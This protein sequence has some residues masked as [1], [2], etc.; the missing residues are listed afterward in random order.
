MRLFALIAL[1]FLAACSGERES[2]LPADTLVRLSSADVRSL[3]PNV[4]TDIV[5]AN[6]AMDQFEGLTRY[7][8]RGEVVGALAESWQVA[9][10]GF[11]WTF[12]LKSGLQFSD[13]T[14][15]DAGLFP[16]LFARIVDEDNPSPHYLLYT[17]VDRIE[18]PDARTVVVRLKQPFPELPALFAHQSMAAVPLHRI[19]ELGE[20]WTAE[21]PMVV[22]GPYRVTEWVLNRRILTEA[23][24][25]YHGGKV[26]IPRVMWRPMDDSLSS[27]RSFLAGEGDISSNY[28]PNREEYI[29]ERM[30]GAVHVF[31]IYGTFFVTLNT[32]KPPLDNRDIRRAMALAVERAWIVKMLESGNPPTWGMIAPGMSELEP[33]KPEWADWS[34]ERR[35]KAAKALMAKAGYGPERPLTLEMR[36]ATSPA[37]RRLA[38]ALQE[39]WKPLG[40]DLKLLNS[41]AGI[42]FATMSLGDFELA[43]SGWL[44]DLPAPENMLAIHRADAGA[45]NYS[46]YPSKEYLR[47]L[48]AAMDEADPDA[49]ASKMRVAEKRLLS[50]MPII[51]I[52]NY[53]S[54]ALVGPRVEGWHDNLADM[55]P[56]VDLSLK[57]P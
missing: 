47:L 17:A 4:L 31:P 22:S 36:F 7:N 8:G 25:L 15:I 29:E 40:V 53:T 14:P 49:R 55:H 9:Q 35:M 24:P 39:M 48:D 34:R 43:N 26:A 3:D 54:R 6:V 1:L 12:R 46:G 37:A 42:H 2:S 38:V 11:A 10:D 19:E 21:R 41:E 33:Y 23:N 13:G 51:P 27:M 32:R 45:S 28:P 18:A 44:A 5:S 30:P 52:Y 50:D 16:R 20:R 56:S 57:A